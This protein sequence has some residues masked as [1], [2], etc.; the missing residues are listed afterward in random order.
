MNNVFTGIVA[1]SAPSPLSGEESK[2]V[3]ESLFISEGMILPDKIPLLESHLRTAATVNVLGH[4][5]NLRI[6]RLP[7]EPGQDHLA[8]I[9][10]IHFSDVSSGAIARRLVEGGHIWGLSVGYEIRCREKISEGERIHYQGQCFRGAMILVKEFTI[11]EVSLCVLPKDRNCRIVGG[12]ER[13]LF[14]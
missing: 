4:A 10:D 1:T 12:H 3:S 5:D 6:R 13:E 7:G 11:V 2:Y 14:Q 8:I 9:A